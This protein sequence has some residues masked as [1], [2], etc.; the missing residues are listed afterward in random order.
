MLK[1]SRNNEFV[2]RQRAIRQE[3]DPLLTVREVRD[4]L[5][6]SASHVQRLVNQ[7]YLDAY[8]I[9]GNRLDP[10]W[11]DVKRNGVRVTPSSVKDLLEGNRL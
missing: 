8:D 1:E 7:G 3:L 5:R 4:I 9:A 10:D 11:V 6:I 2:Q